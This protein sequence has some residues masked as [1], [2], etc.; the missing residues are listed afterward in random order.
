VEVTEP[1]TFGGAE[2]HVYGNYIVIAGAL[3]PVVV[4]HVLILLPRPTEIIL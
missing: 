4:N 2:L 1:V 3:P